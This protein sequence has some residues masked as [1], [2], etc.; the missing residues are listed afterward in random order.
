M[1]TVWVTRTEPG[2]SAMARYLRRAA[3][4]PSVAPLVET[5]GL[6]TTPPKVSF[7]LAVFL[8]QHTARCELARDIVS[9]RYLAIGPATQR[10]LYDIGI[11]SE[12]PE[13]FSSAGLLDRVSKTLDRGSSVLV[14]CGE[15]GMTLL[16]DRLRDLSYN[17]FVWRVYRRVLRS[18]KPI[19]DHAC[20][21][22]ELSSVTSIHA[23]WK[24]VRR[25]ALISTEEP[26]L[27]VPSRRI[28]KQG[29]LLGFGRV[30]IAGDASSR[31]YARVIRR[32]MMSS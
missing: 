30:H 11:A 32:L 13:R 9:E 20:S 22:V 8:S 1:K 21:V 25:F 7:D 28:G 23:Y 26:D 10:A 17:V 15:D 2:A 31:S 29:R 3:I 5:E 4:Q 24:A 18:R 12:L 19:L 27:I 16:S 6:S 14:V